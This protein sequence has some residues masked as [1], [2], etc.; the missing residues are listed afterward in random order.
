VP[1]SPLKNLSEPAPRRGTRPGLVRQATRPLV[2]YVTLA[3]PPPS[4]ASRSPTQSPSPVAQTSPLKVSSRTR[5]RRGTLLL[6]WF[7]RRNPIFGK[8]VTY[9]HPRRAP[10]VSPTQSRHHHGHALNRAVP[11][12]HAASPVHLAIPQPTASPACL[13]GRLSPAQ[14]PS[15]AAYGS[16]GELL[17][18]TATLVIVPP[19]ALIRGSGASCAAP[20]TARVNAGRCRPAVAQTRRALLRRPKHAHHPSASHRGFFSGRTSRARTHHTTVAAL[21][22]TDPPRRRGRRGVRSAPSSSCSAEG[23]P[24]E[25]HQ[26]AYVSAPPAA[27]KG[28]TGR[29][30]GLRKCTLILR[31]GRHEAAGPSARRVSLRGER[32]KARTHLQPSRRRVSCGRRK[33][34]LI[35]VQRPRGFRRGE[36]QEA[37]THLHR[38]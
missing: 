37:R 13:T 23:L 7:D 9:H 5:P 19:F 33:R 31:A 3:H 28:P 25:K 10:H 34:A 1:T 15:S 30:C 14:G 11:D 18:Q 24:G 20:L 26:A 35:L 6:A 8:Y 17:L 16:G 21:A 4:R 27:R 36:R 12:R 32:S 29:P 2:S 22:A 38:D